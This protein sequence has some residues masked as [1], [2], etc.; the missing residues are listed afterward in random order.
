[1]YEREARRATP[2][3]PFGKHKGRTLSEIDSGYLS[4]A[5]ANVK[6]SSGIRQAVAGELA[7]RG[8]RV[9]CPPP[10]PPEPLCPRCGSADR[11]YR[12]GEDR[13]G[14][15]MIRRTCRCCGTWLGF[16][17]K[18]EPYTTEADANANATP[19][20]DVLL[21][22]EAEGVELIS[23]GQQVRIGYGWERASMRLKNAI[24]QRGHLL[25]SL[26]GNTTKRSP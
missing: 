25:A 20:L 8:E 24:R 23:D 15:R 26:L 19:T 14:R 6:L 1:M 21:L 4:W 11:D 10:P 13:L 7:R 2:V 9:P 12:W 22:A 16:A 3:F 5:M 18:I 17:P